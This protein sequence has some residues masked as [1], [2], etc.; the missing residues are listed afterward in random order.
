MK[1]SAGILLYRRITGRTEVMIA[2]Q[3]G[4][5]WAHKDKGAW[6]IPK[7][8]FPEEEAALDAAA[9]EFEEEIGQTVPTA[10]LVPLGQHK[11]TSGKIIHIWTAEFDM[12]VDTIHSNTFEIEW[13]PKSGTM[14]SFPEC[15]RANWF[16]IP[17]ARMKI[18]KGQVI[19]L[20]RLEELLG[21]PSNREP[22]RPTQTSLF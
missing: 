18:T 20:D 17:K 14:E 7:G 2:H 5:F 4:P 10:A 16:T 9:R 1:Q 11:I 21:V 6:T 8:E 22:E 19:F 12:N 15:D 13:P 3:G